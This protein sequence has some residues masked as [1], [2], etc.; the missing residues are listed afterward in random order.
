MTPRLEKLKW[1]ARRGMLELD[2]LFSGFL[3]RCG[4][5][6]SEEQLRNFERLLELEDQTLFDAFSGKIELENKQLDQLF[7]HIK[8][9]KY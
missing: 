7:T 1:R 5:Q 3:A 2:T 9:Q 4:S 6:L 8:Q